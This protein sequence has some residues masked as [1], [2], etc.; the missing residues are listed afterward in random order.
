LFESSEA[1]FVSGKRRR[2]NF[3][4]YIATEFRIAGAPNFTHA[5]FADL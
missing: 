4:G 1:I 2:Q 5:S 3:D